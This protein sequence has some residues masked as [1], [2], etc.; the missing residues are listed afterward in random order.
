MNQKQFFI[1]FLINI[2][3]WGVFLY[4]S[5]FYDSFENHEVR[6]AWKYNF[7]S[8]LLECSNGNSFFNPW[9]IRNKIEDYIEENLENSETGEV[10]YYFHFLKTW[11]NF[12]YNEDTLFSPASLLKIPLAISLLDTY[13]IAELKEKNIQYD[14]DIAVF[15]RN[16]WFDTLEFWKEYRVL[17]V[18]SNML[19]QSDNVAA[20]MLYAFV[21]E[22]KTSEIYR[23]LWITWE[24][25]ER[26]DISVKN[27]SSFLRILYNASYLSRKDSEYLLSLLS[28]ST[29]TE[30]IRY[31]LPGFI[32]ISNKFGE[33]F[34]TDTWE[35]Q[36]HDCWIVYFPNNPY[37]LC[38][39]TKGDDFDKLQTIIQ[40]I[41]KMIYEDV[42][43][44]YPFQLQ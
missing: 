5:F 24:D 18:I 41:S 22:Q 28:R 32:T 42:R 15:E 1:I 30:G 6:D 34:Y 14:M 23:N 36:L 9:K 38:I 29:Y 37:L 21:G 4:F 35:K 27:Y 3:F 8:P 40:T 7:I 17:D 13:S 16:I 25:N 10:S 11:E 19:I 31:Y 20:N 44:K 12:W 26:W 43:L 39:M 2:I 33:R